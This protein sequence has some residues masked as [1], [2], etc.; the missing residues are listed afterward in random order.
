[1]EFTSHLFKR[2]QDRMFN[3]LD[4]R[5]MLQSAKS[6]RTDFVEGRWTIETR[7]EKRAWE[8]VV[9]PYATAE[10]LVVITAY[11]VWEK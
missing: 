5:R 9:E 8:V 1:M 4:L 11:P 3:E 10:L 2:M 7:H 6:Y